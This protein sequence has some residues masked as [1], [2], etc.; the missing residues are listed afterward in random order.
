MEFDILI[1]LH[2]GLQQYKE[3]QNWL[4]SEFLFVTALVCLIP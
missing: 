4:I 2:L 1:I 3:N